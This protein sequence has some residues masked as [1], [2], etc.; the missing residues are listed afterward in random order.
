M[1]ESIDYAAKAGL[2]IIA[3]KTMAGA[4]WDKER[5]QPINTRAALKWV[6]QN[7]NIH[8]TVPGIT[9]FDQLQQNIDLLKNLELTKEERLDLVQPITS[10]P[11]GIFCQQCGE[12]IGQCAKSLD[13]PT[14]MRSFMYAYGYKNLKH[15]HETLFMSEVNGSVCD[16]CSTCHVK[17]A[18]GFD[19]KAKVADISRLKAV[20][21]DLLA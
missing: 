21:G 17:C 13:I 16:D 5:K 9:S 3:M 4:Y 1:N 10:L 20:P 8:T 7:E 11:N 18:S 15:A 2:G 6:L 14:L 19:I 12:C